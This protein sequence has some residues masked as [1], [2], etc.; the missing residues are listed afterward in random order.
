VWPLFIH[1]CRLLE[2]SGVPHVYIPNE[3]RLDSDDDAPRIPV[4]KLAGGRNIPS[5][6]PKKKVSDVY[7]DLDGGAPRIPLNKLAGEKKIPSR[8]T[9]KK[10]CD[11]YDDSDDDAPRIW[12]RYE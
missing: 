2:L 12:I 4:N 3:L 7:A 9:Q 8:V 10:V 5:E 1:H 6:W 11:L